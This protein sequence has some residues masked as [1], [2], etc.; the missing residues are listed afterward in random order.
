MKN[1]KINS[2]SVTF[3]Y[4]SYVAITVDILH[5]DVDRLFYYSV[6][7]ELV[8]DLQVGQRVRV[9]FGKG[10]K[11]ITG[12]VIQICKELPENVPMEKLKAVHS[13]MDGFSVLT[14]DTLQLALWMKD[15]YYTT[16]ISVVRCIIPTAKPDGR[17]PMSKKKP[18]KISATPSNITLTEEQQNAVNEIIEKATLSLSEGSVAGVSPAERRG[19]GGRAPIYNKKAAYAAFRRKHNW[20]FPN[21]AAGFGA[22]PH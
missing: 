8:D 17:F 20:G 16:L 4:V 11:L 9:P 2:S 1:L 6:S 19:F 7:Q 5:G 12:Y 13:I 3:S 10:N 14:P 18:L 21:G 15:K 22:E